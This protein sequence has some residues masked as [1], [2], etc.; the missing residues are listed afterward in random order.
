[1]KIEFKS[2]GF[3]NPRPEEHERKEFNPKTSTF[4]ESVGE[5]KGF[6]GRQFT[7]TNDKGELIGNILLS[8]DDPN[9]TWV[10][11]R[12]FGV[13]KPYMGS[14]AVNFMYDKSF[15]IAKEEGKDLVLDCVATIGAYKSFIKYLDSHKV[16]FEEN[17]LNKYQEEVKT[18]KA[19][20][21]SWTIRV[22]KDNL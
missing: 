11:I 3:K 17:P 4:S 7:L 12:V 2:K 8:M 5:V 18:Y 20:D 22:K 16:K 9:D 13:E 15:E 21:R 6:E 10:K 14:G 19:P 1:M